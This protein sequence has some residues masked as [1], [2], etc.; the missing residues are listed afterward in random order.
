MCAGLEIRK[1][2]LSGSWHSQEMSGARRQ[3]Y[4][5]SLVAEGRLT[6]LCAHCSVGTGSGDDG[7]GES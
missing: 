4:R 3:A 2:K 6:E 1:P 5:S 7:H